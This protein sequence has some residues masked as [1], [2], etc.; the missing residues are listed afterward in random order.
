MIMGDTPRESDKY[1]LMYECYS[2]Y[3]GRMISVLQ[4]QKKALK[5]EYKA[6]KLFNMLGTPQTFNVLAIKDEF[7]Y[8]W[9][10]AD[11]VL[12]YS[13]IEKCPIVVQ[14]HKHLCSEMMM[15]KEGCHHP[16]TIPTKLI[17]TIECSNYVKFVSGELWVVSSLKF[18][19]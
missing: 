13:A 6:K 14:G 9:E 16:I 3:S 1:Y 7:Q 8:L 5:K 15:V 18:I 17:E 12:L 11:V 4:F 19:Y 10:L 2:E